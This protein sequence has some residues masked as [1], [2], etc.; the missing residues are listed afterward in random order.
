M[1][2]KDK[3]TIKLPEDIACEFDSLT[4]VF[5][6]EYT[7]NEIEFYSIYNKEFDDTQKLN[8]D[9]WAMDT[10]R[11]IEEEGGGAVIEFLWLTYVNTIKKDAE[12]QDV[13]DFFEEI[14]K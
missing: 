7:E 12:E 10:S 9:K 3:V 4:F 8:I 5:T 11:Q 6:Y 13:R 14:S 2:Y 1:E